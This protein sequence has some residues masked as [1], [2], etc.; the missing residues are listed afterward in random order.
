MRKTLTLAVIVLLFAGMAIAAN[1]ES[2]TTTLKDVQPAGTTNKQHKKQQYDLSFA[3][4]KNDYT[5]RSNENEKVNATDWVVGTSINY[6][7]NG[8][9]GEVKNAASGKKVK[10]TVVRVAAVTR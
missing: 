8:N 3:T 10:C 2:G 5:C 4:S 7:V 6:N 1:K 9:K